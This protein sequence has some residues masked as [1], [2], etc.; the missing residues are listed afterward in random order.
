VVAEQPATAARTAVA[1]ATS[2]RLVGKIMTALPR[3]GDETA[4]DR[5]WTATADD[6]VK[7]GGL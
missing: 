1:V 5:R 7:I 2:H 6:H 3:G 4:V